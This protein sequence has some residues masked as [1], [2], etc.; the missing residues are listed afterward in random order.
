MRLQRHGR[1]LAL[2]IAAAEIRVDW[3]FRN[4]S[5]LE[6]DTLQYLSVHLLFDA[7]VLS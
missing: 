6:T 7:D 3:L 4:R 2:T 1:H 5:I